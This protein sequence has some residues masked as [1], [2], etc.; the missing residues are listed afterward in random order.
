MVL[1]SL[2]PFALLSLPLVFLPP[3]YQYFAKNFQMANRIR[4]DN[5]NTA[6]YQIELQ[7]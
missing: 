5:K 1:V 2:V 6:L 3:L 7:E 4:Q